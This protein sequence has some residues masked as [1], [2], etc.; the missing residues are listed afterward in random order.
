MRELDGIKEAME[1]NRLMALAAPRPPPPLASDIAR[2]NSIALRVQDDTITYSVNENRRNLIGGRN[3]SERITPLF[4]DNFVDTFVP[5]LPRPPLAGFLEGVGLKRP[6]RN[7]E[8]VSQTPYSFARLNGVGMMPTMDDNV[9][10]NT[11]RGT[12]LKFLRSKESISGFLL[13]I[14]VCAKHA[15]E[16]KAARCVAYY[17]GVMCAE[18]EYAG[19]NLDNVMAKMR[20]AGNALGLKRVA[21]AMDDIIEIFREHGGLYSPSVKPFNFCMDLVTGDVKMTCVEWMRPIQQ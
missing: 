19:E 16:F 6:V 5:S 15:S 1:R 4:V 13:S 10:I 12:V 20:A 2:V 7:N 3:H 11:R 8:F 9:L 18:Y 17:P 21:T 14:Y